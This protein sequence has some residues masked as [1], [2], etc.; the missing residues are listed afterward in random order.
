MGNYTTRSG[1]KMQYIHIKN[2]ERFNPGYTD[3]KHIWAKIYWD[4][5][6][7][8]NF[9][10]L[11]EVDR[12]RLISLIVAEV[13]RGKPIPLT[14]AN[15]VLMGWDTKKRSISLTLQ[16]LHNSIDVVTEDRESGLPEESPGCIYFL[17]SAQRN[18]IKIGWDFNTKEDAEQYFN[19]HFQDEPVNYEIILQS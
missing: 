12:Y 17:K 18:A 6:L 16:M 15:L 9:Q 8:E 7:D 5:F 4:I 11:C 14:T 10:A 13:Y 1:H 2:L 3:R 19:Q